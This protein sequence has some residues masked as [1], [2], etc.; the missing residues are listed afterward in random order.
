MKTNTI[1]KSVSEKGFIIGTLL[2]GTGLSHITLAQDAP[3]SI[4]EIETLRVVK[5]LSSRYPD[6]G[7][8]PID[9]GRK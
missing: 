6:T 4:I 2:L 5:V 1:N 9:T 7:T 3:P 8:N